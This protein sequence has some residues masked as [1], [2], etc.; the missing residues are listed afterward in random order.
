MP[1]VECQNCGE[2]SDLT[3]LTTG[4]GI[5]ISCNRCGHRWM[6]DTDPSCRDCGSNDVVPFKEPLV[7]RAR[8]NAYSVVGQKTI[9]LCASCD[10]VEIERRKPPPEAE[11]AREDPWK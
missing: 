9:Y 5:Q 1:I 2:D 10:A 7:Q 6:R 3:G 4:D 8:G 11:R